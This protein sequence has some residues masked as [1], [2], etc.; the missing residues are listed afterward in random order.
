MGPLR[1]TGRHEHL[2]VVLATGYLLLFALLPTVHLATAPAGHAAESCPICYT[3]QRH[4]DL[5]L[6]PAD[7]TLPD[8]CPSR[9]LVV[10]PMAYAP[11]A[12]GVVPVSRAP[13]AV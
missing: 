6:A 7:A 12:P 1:T 2:A 4:A 3:L 8:Q 11:G 10:A 13:P 5:T 9:P